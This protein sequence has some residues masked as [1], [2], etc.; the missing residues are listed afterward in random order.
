MRVQQCKRGPGAEGAAQSRGGRRCN[1][2]GSCSRSGGRNDGRSA[3]TRAA[4]LSPVVML[5]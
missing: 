1:D 3:P 2:T 4:L 5:T